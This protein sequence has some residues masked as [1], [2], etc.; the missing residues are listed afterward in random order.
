MSP[1]IMITILSKVKTPHGVGIVTKMEIPSNGLMIG[2]EDNIAVTVWYGV[3]NS[4]EINGA[5]W[6]TCTYFLPRIE[7]A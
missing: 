6:S 5:K 7:L 4:V 2:H 3:D 1:E